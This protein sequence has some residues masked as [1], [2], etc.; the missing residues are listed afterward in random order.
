MDRQTKRGV[1]GMTGRWKWGHGWRVCLWLCLCFC[2][3]VFGCEMLVSDQIQEIAAA[4]VSCHTVRDG[5]GERKRWKERMLC[6]SK[7]K[8]TLTMK[9]IQHVDGVYAVTLTSLA[10][11][12]RENK[13]KTE[14]Q[15]TKFSYS[16]IM[17]STKFR[18]N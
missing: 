9:E 8:K 17:G 2:V 16:V 15:I 14:A 12:G 18:N 13:S 11:H 7:R 10:C 6:V 3:C 1:E 4:Y 5:E